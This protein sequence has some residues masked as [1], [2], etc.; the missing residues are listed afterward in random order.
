MSASETA[1]TAPGTYEVAVSVTGLWAGPH[2]PRPLDAA[3]TDPTPRLADWLTAQAPA[4]RREL[5]GHL[6]SQLLLGERVLVH[7][8][9][10][11][12]AR[13]SAPEQPSSRDDAGYPGFVPVHHLR[14]AE[15]APS[16]PRVVVHRPVAAIR[17]APDG[18]VLIPDVG[19]ATA[20]A[21][22]DHTA[23]AVAVRLPGGATGWLPAA[24]V[25][26][27]R[28]PD[29]PPTGA[30]LV[31][32]GRAFLGVGYLPGGMHGLSLDCSGLVHALYRRF[33]WT[34]PRDAGDQVSLGTP[35]ALGGACPGDLLFF[36]NP[37]TRAIYHVGLSLGPL[38][39]LHAAQADGATTEGPLSQRLRDHLTD[40]RRCHS[41]P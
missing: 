5:W 10:D 25:E 3:L 4:Q 20:L 11:G 41:G 15:A 2:A 35:V 1:E 33:G 17:D 31:A 27:L 19:F 29:V 30:E 34:V 24:H 40:V 9:A 18:A 36:T 21:V 26:Q 13:V 8:V 12:W 32:A 14:P 38:R 7:T 6:E 37:R 28:P 39:M 16:G 23:E 22:L